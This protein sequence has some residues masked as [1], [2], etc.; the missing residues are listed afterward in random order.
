MA[1]P[2]VFLCAI[3]LTFGFA[4][5]AGATPFSWSDTDKSGP[6]L[7]VNWD[8]EFSFQSGL[9]G[10]I[11]DHSV[12]FDATSDSAGW[13]SDSTFAWSWPPEMQR[14]LWPPVRNSTPVQPFLL[15]SMFGIPPK[16]Q[17]PASA[18]E[19]TTMLLLGCGLVGLAAVGRK[20]FQ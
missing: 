1:K 11:I 16:P 4:G 7:S 12:I 20:K 19:P 9:V 14:S 8:K 18:P 10:S 15:P 5:V 2:L 3:I 6:G 17:S 13:K